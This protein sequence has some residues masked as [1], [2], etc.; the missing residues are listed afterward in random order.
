[1]NIKGDYYVAR[2]CGAR[3]FSVRHWKMYGLFRKINSGFSIGPVL[4]W[5]ELR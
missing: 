4:F 1:M 5:K 3:F 2:Y